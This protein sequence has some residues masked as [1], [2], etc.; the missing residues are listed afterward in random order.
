MA[1]ILQPRR[2][3]NVLL[4]FIIACMQCQIKE[5]KGSIIRL[6]FLLTYLD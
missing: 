6:I 1:S 4:R 2:E 5:N 3:K